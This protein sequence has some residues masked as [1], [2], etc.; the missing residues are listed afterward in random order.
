MQLALASNSKS[1]HSTQPSSSCSTKIHT[2]LQVLAIMKL[3]L[4]RML[5]KSVKEK[6]IN[7][8]WLVK[9]WTHSL[10]C[11]RAVLWVWVR[12]FNSV[13]AHEDTLKDVYIYIYISIYEWLYDFPDFLFLFH[14][15]DLSVWNNCVL[16][17][18]SNVSNLFYST[19]SL[20]IMSTFLFCRVTD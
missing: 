2:G 10:H 11:C 5:H 20:H 6:I 3:Q 15:T 8:L 4:I 18:V 13:S 17:S 1:T 9:R 14:P 12:A 16:K 7:L 19:H